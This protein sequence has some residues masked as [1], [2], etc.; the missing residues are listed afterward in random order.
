MIVDVLCVNCG[1]VVKAKEPGFEMPRHGLAAR[2]CAGS[3]MPGTPMVL[4]HG[5][6]VPARVLVRV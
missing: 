5:S 4:I 2:K 3:G 6:V 1:A